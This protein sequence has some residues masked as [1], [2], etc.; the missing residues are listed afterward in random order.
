MAKKV[1]GIIL[2][3][4]GGL[5]LLLAFI[6]GLVFGGI[7]TAMNGASDGMEDYLQDP[8]YIACEGEVIDVDDSKTIVEYEADGYLYTVEL[9]MS[10]SAYPTGTRVTVYYNKTK[11]EACTIPEIAE[12]TFGT[13]GSIF[14]GM[15]I[16]F[17]I[18]FAVLGVAALVGGILLIRSAAKSR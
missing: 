13:I 11:P 1:I 4:A 7:G 9:N 5:F 18:A 15:G 8:N 3:V 16:V 10:S 12:A 14:S 2:T 17:L 6:F